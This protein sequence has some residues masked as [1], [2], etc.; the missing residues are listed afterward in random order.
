[1]CINFLIRSNWRAT[2][3]LFRYFLLIDS[4]NGTVSPHAPSSPLALA[5]TMTPTL[6]L[7]A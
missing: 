2:C 3:I 4:N 7:S 1:L 5:S 6:V